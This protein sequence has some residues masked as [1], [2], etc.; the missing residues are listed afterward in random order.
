[1]QRMTPDIAPSVTVLRDAICMTGN[2]GSIR[3]GKAHIS[4]T[5]ATMLAA[6]GEHDAPAIEQVDQLLGLATSWRRQHL[7]AIIESCTPSGARLVLEEDEDE[8]RKVAMLVDD[9]AGDTQCLGPNGTEAD[10]IED[11]MSTGIA[12]GMVGRLGVKDATI[13]AE[14]LARGS[15]ALFALFAL[16]GET[17]LPRAA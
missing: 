4:S 13:A 3:I 9:E 5:V 6:I 7:L 12:E 8:P 16:T 17:G 2:C 14:R 1:M 15:D 10:E 11:W